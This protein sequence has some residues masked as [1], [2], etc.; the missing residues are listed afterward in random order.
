MLGKTIGNY[1]VRHKLGE[2]GMG[3]VYFAEHPSI[4]K[5]VA[6]KVLHPDFA[7]D[8]EIVS[9]FF[10]EAK[11]VNDIQ[12]PNIIDIID[13]GTI[14]PATPA[15]HPLVYFIMEYIEGVSLTDLIK[16]EAPLSP[17]RAVTIALQIAD[18]LAASHR[19][20]VIHRDL[21][22]DNVMLVSRG[23][24]RDFVKLLDFGIAK[25]TDGAASTHRTRTGTVMG[26][27]QYM[28]PEQ[29]DGHGHIDHR[30]DVYALGIVL[31]Q[32][33]TGRVPFGG[34]GL[35]EVLIQQMT[36]PPLAPSLIAPHIPEHLELVVLKALEKRPDDR[37]QHIDE[38]MPALQDPVHYV[39]THGGRASFLRSPVVREP[40]AAGSRTAIATLT[41]APDPIPTTLSGSASQLVAPPTA[42]PRKR[43]PVGFGLAVALFVGAIAA[44]VIFQGNAPPAPATQPLPASKPDPAG[45]GA[46]PVQPDPAPRVTAPVAEPRPRRPVRLNVN[47]T[48][49]GASVTIDGEV[50]GKT[51]YAGELARRDAP[52]ELQL[53]LAGYLPVTRKI[54][55]DGNVVLTLTLEPLP[56]PTQ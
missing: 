42:A 20:G 37:F 19:N 31:Y 43:F 12:H 9:R 49:P 22:P 55:L 47:S 35:G 36:K 10:N 13:F 11:A 28:S 4:G 32:M 16:R 27:P 17:D 34:D 41:A 7:S 46:A 24:Q 8:P 56:K 45:P 53:T 33:L 30:A 50:R 23:R 14:A 1:I 6:L 29:C 18:A 38:M 26:T 52:I 15:D 25:L 51:P 5:R 3:S 40:G 44:G 2:G 48:P 54:A 21:K 39:A